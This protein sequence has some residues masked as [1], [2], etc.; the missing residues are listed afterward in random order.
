MALV[1]AVTVA[2]AVIGL[3]FLLCPLTIQAKKLVRKGKMKN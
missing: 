2:S 3:C 1:Q